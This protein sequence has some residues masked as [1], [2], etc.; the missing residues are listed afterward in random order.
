MISLTNFLLLLILA[1]FT[2]YTFM[3]WQGI[4][5]ESKKRIGIQFLA[6]VVLFGTIIFALS[7]I[8][9]LI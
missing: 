8:D 3:S 6:W 7:S 5:K 2:T 9:F 1:S 4:Q